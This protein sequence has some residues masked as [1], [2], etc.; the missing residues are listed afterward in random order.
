MFASVTSVL[1][2]LLL[3]ETDFPSCYPR[4]R[5]AARL[6]RLASTKALPGIR[7]K[8]S[9]GG[10]SGVCHV[11]SVLLL[12]ALELIAGCVDTCAIELHKHLDSHFNLTIAHA[13]PV[14]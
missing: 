8:D 9:G 6:E 2:L 13:A 12:V 4:N 11:G 1:G 3:Y 14:T 10:C 5:W 7:Q